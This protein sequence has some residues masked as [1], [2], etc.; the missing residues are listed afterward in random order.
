MFVK[1]IEHLSDKDA[2]YL[3]KSQGI[4]HIRL[5]SQI[6]KVMVLKITLKYI[7]TVQLEKMLKWQIQNTCVIRVKNKNKPGQKHVFLST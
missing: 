3:K 2:F 7:A 6:E 1:Q 5:L 4:L